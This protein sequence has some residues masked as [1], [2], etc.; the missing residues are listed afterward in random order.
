[1]ITVK[2]SVIEKLSFEK[3]AEYE[4]PKNVSEWNEEILDQFFEQ[5]NY[6]P[7]EFGV[8]VIVKSVDENEGYA[9]GSV[10]VWYEGKQINFPVIVKDFKLSP[11]DV[12]VHQDG[13]TVKYISANLA[14]IKKIL[15][16]EK[17]G[18]P[19]RKYPRGA[20]EAIKPVGGIYPKTSVNINDVPELSAYPNF[21]KM[22]AWPVLAHEEDI[23]KFAVQL[24]AK[25]DVSGNFVDNTGDLVGNIVELNRH[26]RIVGDDHKDGILDTYKIVKAKR[27][28]TVLD[29]QFIDVNKLQPLTAPV[30]CELRMYEYPTMEDFIES[31]KNMAGRFLAT[32]TGK[33]IAGMILDMV[34]SYDLKNRECTPEPCCTSDSDEIEK[35]KKQ[36]NRRNQIFLSLDGKYY[37]KFNDYNRHGIGFYG[38]KTLTQDGALQKA[39]Q[40]FAKRVTD[41]FINLD[42]K[43]R[44][45]GADKSFNLNMKPMEQGKEGYDDD[46]MC[47][48]GSYGN[49]LFII[50]GANN[51]FEC[52]TFSDRFRKFKV[53]NSHV[54]VSGKEAIIPANIA[55]VQRVKKVLDPVYKMILG[56]VKDIFLVPEGA[57]II[58]A[59]MMEGLNNDDFLRPAKSIQQTYEDANINKI[60]MSVD[61][62][63]YKIIG[64]PFEPLKKIAGLNGYSMTTGQT[65]KSLQ[66]MGMSKDAATKAMKVVLAKYAND[67]IKN[68]A[69]TIY[70]VNNNYINLGVL[71]EIEK[72]AHIK[73]VIKEVCINMRVDLVKEASVLDDPDAVDVVL[74]LNFINEDNL[75]GYV[76]NVREMKKVAGDLAELLVASR[77]GLST[78]NEGAVKKAMDGLNTVVENLEEIK[79]A[80]E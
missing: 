23:E 2:E 1:M 39:V 9:K 54:Y 65:I 58:N 27:A 25:K 5:I 3:V 18:V 53:N 21:A 38:T 71:E 33:P 66:L 35:K 64:E 20:F 43:N 63:G 15:S 51:A 40:Y 67:E 60:A 57:L 76:E 61:G 19:K 46:G 16:S 74:S 79:M 41:D 73:D 14:N 50:Y 11:F 70:G 6:L 32:T 75:R 7:K 17:L 36:R 13:E 52:I 48:G 45:D 34:D 26:Q 68:K 10:A 31:G 29:S 59:T 42:P 12:F 49:K 37:C 30:V 62:E 4:L 24:E 56:N 28:I 22:S 78:I 80:T 47:C 77:M 44:S 72:I 8:D 55:S 69:V